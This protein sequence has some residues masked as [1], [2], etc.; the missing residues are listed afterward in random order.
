MKKS[1]LF[2]VS[3]KEVIYTLIFLILAVLLVILLFYMFLPDKDDSAKTASVSSYIPGVYTSCLNIDDNALTLQMTVDKENINSIELIDA[4]E[5]TSA[6]YPLIPTT[7]ESINAQLSSGTPIE[8]LSVSEES[9][10]TQL[11]LTQAIN[12]LLTKA[13]N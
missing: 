5:T 3:I 8:E 9:K 1:R 12:D 7:L 6:M 4:D 11:L 13:K 10:Y 2:V